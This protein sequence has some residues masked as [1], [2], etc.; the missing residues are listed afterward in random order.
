MFAIFASFVSFLSCSPEQLSG[1][2]SC[3]HKRTLSWQW[4]PR[5][6]PLTLRVSFP[7]TII[8]PP[9]VGLW[10]AECMSCCLCIPGLS[11]S[12]TAVSAQRGQ[13]PSFIPPHWPPL[14]FPPAPQGSDCPPW[15]T[16]WPFSVLCSLP[17]PREGAGWGLGW[18]TKPRPQGESERGG[19]TSGFTPDSGF[20]HAG[21]CGAPEG[22]GS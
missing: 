15:P 16:T 9:T 14:A 4:D 19:L 1:G 13:S 6:V 20:L 3:L 7:N 21:L 18:S 22:G 17:G 2:D 10:A 8:T 5:Q 12:W 11:P